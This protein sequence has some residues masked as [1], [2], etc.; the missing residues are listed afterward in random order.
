MSTTDTILVIILTSLLS[1]F[2]IMCIVLTVGLVKL[3]NGVRRVVEKAE[4]LV[5]SVEEA[6]EVFRD[7]QGKLAIVKLVRNIVKLAQK[8]SEHGQKR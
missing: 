4:S 5:D 3:V 8:R 1:L 6:A 7:T 2:F